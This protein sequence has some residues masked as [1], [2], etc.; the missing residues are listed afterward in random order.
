MLKKFNKKYA[1]SDQLGVGLAAVIIL[2]IIN[3]F[4]EQE[5]LWH[6]WNLAVVL[7]PLFYIA[8]QYK[9]KNESKYL[10]FVFLAMAS[11]AVIGMG[12]GGHWGTVD[13]ESMEQEYW[14]VIMFYVIAL[15]SFLIGSK[16]RI[17]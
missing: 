6:V 10:V 16:M 1:Y 17:E 13:P 8:T 5:T 2:G 14:E 4:A 12:L 7:V 3:T 11:I 9:A 15:Y